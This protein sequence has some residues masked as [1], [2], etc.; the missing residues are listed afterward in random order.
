MMCIGADFQQA[1]ENSLIPRYQM[2]ALGQNLMILDNRTNRVSFLYKKRD[3]QKSPPDW[4]WAIDNS[5]S[6]DDALSKRDGGAINP[7]IGR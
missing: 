4:P 3:I 6:L 5:F 1:G 2:T 7:G